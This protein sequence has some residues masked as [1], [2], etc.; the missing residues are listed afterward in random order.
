MNPAD[1]KPL[2]KAAQENEHGLCIRTNNPAVLRDLLA[3]LQSE[4]TDEDDLT[5]LELYLHPTETD[6]L[7]IVKPPNVLDDLFEILEEEGE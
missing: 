1:Y 2:L 7:F 6:C 5:V 3:K 4:L